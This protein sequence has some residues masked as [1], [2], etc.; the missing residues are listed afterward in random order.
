MKFHYF[1]Y[2]F[3]KVSYILQWQFIKTNVTKPSLDLVTYN[4]SVATYLTKVVLFEVLLSD[5]T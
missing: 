4:K 2:T 1:F 3:Y 5:I